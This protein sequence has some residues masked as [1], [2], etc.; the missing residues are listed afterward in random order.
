M[1]D[2]IQIRRASRPGRF[3]R[4]ERQ[5][6]QFGVK[7]L[8]NRGPGVWCFQFRRSLCGTYFHLCYWKSWQFAPVP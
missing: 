2:S 6:V 7:F 1:P 4:R 5:E 3:L 8:F